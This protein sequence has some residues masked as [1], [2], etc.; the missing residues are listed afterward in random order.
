MTPTPR[1]RHHP[2]RGA[3]LRRGVITLGYRL[4]PTAN[5]LLA[6]IPIPTWAQRYYIACPYCNTVRRD[7]TDYCPECNL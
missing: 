1:P 5:R 7:P 6:R 3:R 4:I 2:T